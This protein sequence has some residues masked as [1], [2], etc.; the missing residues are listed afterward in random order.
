MVRGVPLTLHAALEVAAAPAIMVAPFLFGFGEAAGV[1]T[2]ALGA[3][4]LGHAIQIEAP[5][6]TMSLSAH[7][8]ID[9]ALAAI[10][11]GAGLALMLAAGELVAG[12]LLVGVGAAQTALTAATRFSV[13]V[14]A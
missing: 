13:P 12:S 14:R 7:A 1:L 5:R 4:L 8:A 3:I 10:A 2:F 6:R 9:Y 11:T